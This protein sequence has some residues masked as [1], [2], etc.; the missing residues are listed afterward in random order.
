MKLGGLSRQTKIFIKCFW[1]IWQ[2][3]VTYKGIR[4]TTRLWH[5]HLK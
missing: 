2:F 1:V 5:D 4:L 3:L